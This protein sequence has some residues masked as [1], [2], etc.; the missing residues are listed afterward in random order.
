MKV[1]LEKF[2]LKEI[3]ITK[4]ETWEWAESLSSLNIQMN[5]DILLGIRV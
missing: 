5:C 2:K 4:C 1:H 3:V